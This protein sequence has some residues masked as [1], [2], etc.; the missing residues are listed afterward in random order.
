[1][2]SDLFTIIKKELA[3]FFGDKRMVAA[4]IMPGVLI[5]VMYTFMGSGMS[6]VYNTDENYVCDVSV[7]NMPECMEFLKDV[8][9]VEISEI[10]EK[11]IDV[12]KDAIKEDESDL[13]MIFPAEF[14][15]AI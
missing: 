15:T 12:V 10:K 11:D 5:Y 8:E 13:L 9:D 6:E 1:M 2:K 7:V 3:R 14:D 4:A